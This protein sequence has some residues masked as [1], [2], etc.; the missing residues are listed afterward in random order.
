MS[1]INDRPGLLWNNEAIRTTLL[2]E[3]HMI[4]AESRFLVL[5]LTGLVLRDIIGT[6]SDRFPTLQAHIAE[7][8]ADALAQVKQ[9]SGWQYAFLNL[10]PDLFVASE[11][12]LL[13]SQAGAKI[14][15]MGS[16]AEDAAA[17][18]AHT[19]LIRPFT[20]DDVLQALKR[21]P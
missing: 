12:S 8:E 14:V 19:V 3:L 11:L 5:G 15:L 9:A 17:Q 4:S 20:A 18:S 2:K 21:E 16:E 10:G 1:N 13:L 7:D 6:L